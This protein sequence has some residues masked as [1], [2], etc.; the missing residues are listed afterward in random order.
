MM[1]LDD[2]GK[3]ILKKGNDY[4]SLI[5]SKTIRKI[6]ADMYKR[7]NEAFSSSR[8]HHIQAYSITK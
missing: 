4:K 2:V 7:E 6:I 3:H 5:V 1:K 8:Y